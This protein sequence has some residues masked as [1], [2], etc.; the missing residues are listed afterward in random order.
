[1]TY[2]KFGCEFKTLKES[3]V[4]LKDS[5]HGSLTM[6]NVVFET[7]IVDDDILIQNLNQNLFLELYE[8]TLEQLQEAFLEF[9]ESIDY[10]ILKADIRR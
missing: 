10:G 6:K 8:E 7:N 3:G 4:Q 5:V 1:M 9:K 2:R